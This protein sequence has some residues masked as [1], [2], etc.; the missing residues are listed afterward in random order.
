M[1]ALGTTPLLYSARPAL[2]VEG[3]EEADLALGLLELSVVET[4]EGLYRC[5]ATFGNWGSI[6]GGIGYLYFDRQR[7]DFGHRLAIEAGAPG[8]RARLFDGRITALEGR[9]PADRPAEILVLAEDRFQDLRMVRRTRTFEEASDADVIEQIARQHGLATAVDLDG[10]THRVLAQVN[11]SDLAFLRDRARAADGELWLADG[12]LHAQARSRRRQGEVTLTHGQG[13][14]EFS[15]LADLAGQRTRL[16]VAGWDVAA[17][18]GLEHG[19]DDAAVRGELDGGL[20]GGA[21]LGERFGERPERLVHLVPLSS[22]EAQQL[23]QAHFRRMARRFVTGRGRAEGDPRIR[24]GTH[25][26][27]AGLGD[28]FS[29]RYYVTQV[30]H[31]FDNRQGFRTAFEVERPGLGRVR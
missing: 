29:G 17:K 14:V 26:R 2:S 11:Q 30:H 16:S 9:F 5:E 21:L 25:L 12:T 4:T 24:V 8:S 3:R 18:E 20:S 15:A 27:L 31:T 19:E 28:L 13:L 7:L 1:G 23:A 10:P 22:Q 6:P